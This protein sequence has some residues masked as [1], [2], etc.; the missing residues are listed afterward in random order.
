MSETTVET[1]EQAPEA[2][3]K[4]FDAEY[5]EKLRRENAKWRNEARANA[6]AA[7]RLADLEDANKSETQ[8]VTERLAEA[9]RKAL[10]AE[11]R[12][13]RRDV[14]IEHKLTAEDAALLDTITDEAAMRALAVRLAPAEPDNNTRRNHVPREG[15]NPRPASDPMRDFARDLF[16][17]AAAD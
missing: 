2:E 4:T 11:A 12:V 8:K 3:P 13:L 10:E 17:R 1:P 16:G 7:K 15:T 14:A 9:E 5:V 6:E